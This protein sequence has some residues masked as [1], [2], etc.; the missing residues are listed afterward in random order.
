MRYFHYCAVSLALLPT[1]LLAQQSAPASTPDRARISMNQIWSSLPDFVCNEK[2][3]STLVEKGKTKQQRVI[4]SVFMIQRKT[5]STA[6]HS[7]VESRELTA[8]GKKAVAKNAKLP[9]LPL[10]FDGLAANILFIS[11][12]PGYRPGAA[13]NLEGRLSVRITFS[14][15]KSQEFVQLEFPAAVMGAQIDTQARSAL[16]VENRLASLQRAG[17]IPVSADFQTVVIDGKPY[18]LPRLVRAEATIGKTQ[19]AAYVAEY[20]DCRKFEVTTQIRPVL[21]VP[22]P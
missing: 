13:G 6:T 14:T 9:D 3:I 10:S 21:D 12:V 2:I 7:I 17:G 11:D 15:G 16:H 20:T 5:D 19:N 1:S 8:I 22:S 4:E 18:W